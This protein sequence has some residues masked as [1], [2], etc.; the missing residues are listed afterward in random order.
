MPKKYPHNS[1]T[2]QGFARLLLLTVLGL[3]GLLLV[4]NIRVSSSKPAANNIHGVFLAK[5]GGDSGSSG[6]SDSG[7]HDSDS[8]KTSGSGGTSGSGD[9]GSKSS[10][11]T[12][13]QPPANP[14][15][16]TPKPSKKPEVK[17][18]KK[19]EQEK[20]H[21]LENEV[22]N[23]LEDEEITKVEFKNVGG[24]IEIEAQD[25]TGS[26]HHRGEH[27]GKKAKVAL[28]IREATQEAELEVEGDKL[29]FEVNG[30]KATSNF[31][32]TVDQNGQLFVRTGKGLK[33]IRILPDEAAEIAKKAG[34]QNQIE[35]IELVEN[36]IPNASEDVVFKLTGQRTGNLFGFIPVRAE[37]ETEVGA[38]TGNVVKVNEPF[39]IRLLSRAII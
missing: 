30:G 15:F 39:W 6:S 2:N 21:A 22:E 19:I 33:Q 12:S 38:Q 36:E 14:V 37:V 24:E 17:E 9:S 5:D 20:E 3:G 34:V 11:T 4:A 23:E 18:D 35:K 10:D 13:S 8:S 31:P 32:L 27:K 25:A 26:A 1:L 7:S 16:F 28:R 29:N